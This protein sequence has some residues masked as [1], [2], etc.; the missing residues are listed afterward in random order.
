MFSQRLRAL[1]FHLRS[2]EAVEFQVN[3]GSGQIPGVSEKVGLNPAI[4]TVECRSRPQIDGSGEEFLFGEN[5]AT[6]KNSIRRKTFVLGIQVGGGETNLLAPTVPWNNPTKQGERA[7]E[8][9][10]GLVQISFLDGFPYPT[11]ADAGAC[12]QDWVG[13]IEEDFSVSAPAA[14][15]FHIP[16]PVFTESPIRPDGNGF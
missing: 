1:K 5:G 4:A 3:F 7:T 9:G 11:T 10:R 14:E 12:V 2:N 13:I 16:A 15:K 6:G 8:H